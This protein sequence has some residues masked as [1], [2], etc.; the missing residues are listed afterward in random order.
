MTRTKEQALIAAKTK[1]WCE[2]MWNGPGIDFPG[3]GNVYLDLGG[4]D[5][6]KVAGAAR[7][8][9]SK[10]Q[11]K[12]EGQ[13]ALYRPKLR[14]TIL[15]QAERIDTGKGLPR[16]VFR[17]ESKA[18]QPRVEAAPKRR[19]AKAPAPAYSTGPDAC[20]HV[21]AREAWRVAELAALLERY[22][23]PMRVKAVDKWLP[24]QAWRAP[25]TS[26]QALAQWTVERLARQSIAA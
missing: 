1:A 26:P 25:Y 12:R 6:R 19:K 10:E 5:Y 11:R 22:P 4:G 2:A 23:A 8:T 14:E 7:D 20:A 15:A 16:F 3:N 18:P 13:F 17:N 24:G 21:E 9:R